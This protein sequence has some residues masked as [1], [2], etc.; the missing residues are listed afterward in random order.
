MFSINLKKTKIGSFTASYSENNTPP[1]ISFFNK[2]SMLSSYRTFTQGTDYMGF[3]KNTRILFSHTLFNDEKRFSIETSIYYSKSKDTYTQES[4]I[5]DNFSFE[6]YLFYTG[7]SNFNGKFNIVNYFRKLKIATKLETVQNWSEKPTRVNN[8]DFVN[9][10]TYS[11]FY[12]F[13][14]TT[15]FKLP[16]NFDFGFNFNNYK[17]DFNAIITKNKTR[18]AFVNCNYKITKT[19][20]AE[21]N[22]TFYQIN[23]TNYSFVN[24][25][26]NY[27]PENS[28]FSYRLVLN[29]FTNENEFTNVLLDNYTF[30]KSSIQLVPR[31][32]LLTVKY[33]F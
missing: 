28:R 10:K 4:I 23:N 21:I 14:A 6:K 32:L 2:N 9:I 3:L 17:T 1:D 11:S 15:Y 16:L 7:N 12:K 29:N 20:I 19:W 22:S 25:I 27:T 18:D 5:T 8:I 13:S 33:R 31:Y 30:Y 24:A 26:I